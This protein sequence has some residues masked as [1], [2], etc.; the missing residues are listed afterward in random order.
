[1][2]VFSC[3][4][5]AHPSPQ[6]FFI[7]DGLFNTLVAVLLV[8]TFLIACASPLIRYGFRRRVIRLMGLNQVEPR[9]SSWWQANDKAA[10]KVI[11]P[12]GSDSAESMAGDRFSMAAAW[13]NRITLAT[14]L[15]WLA[16]ALMA[17]PV[18]E[19][20]DPA[21]GWLGQVEFAVAAG[22][23][24]LGPL[25]VNLPVHWRRKV[26]IMGLV[27]VAVAVG[28]L[29]IIDIPGP[30]S[31]PE[32][33]DD[34]WPAWLVSLWMAVFFGVYMTLFHRR[35]RGLVVP[36]SLVIAVFTMATVI[37][38]ALVE[39]HLGTCLWN[40]TAENPVL[41]DAQSQRFWGLLLTFAGISL[42]V[43]GLW[44]GL[45]AIGILARLVERGWLGDLSMVSVIGLGMIAFVMIFT[46][47]PGEGASY[48]L[49]VAWLPLV[50]L[51]APVG[52][53]IIVLGRRS[54]AGPGLDLLMLR[55][56]SRHSREQKFL[57]QVQSRWRYLGAVQQAGGP[58]LVDINVSPYEC[59][60][61]LSSRLHDLYLP[62]ALD[63]D[64]LRGRFNYLPDREGRYR[65]N[66]MF[67]FN[68]A[69]RNNVEQLI[70]LSKTIMLDL[71]G[72]TAE[73]EGT[74]YEIGLLARHGLLHRVVAIGDDTTDWAHVDRQLRSASASL[75]QLKRVDITSNQDQD[76]LIAEL[77]KVAV[78]QTS[79]PAQ[80]PENLSH[81][82]TI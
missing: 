61:F 39:E 76:A 50:W 78:R 41:D 56:F 47:I 73:R 15:A 27:T 32:D 49:W 64:Q 58:D 4:E 45:H 33:L 31:S 72:L 38:Y 71:R 26:L 22:A 55:V 74:S 42:A 20:S 34:E 54:E 2:S 48:S 37:P 40:L 69:W 36:L 16:F 82:H 79:A 29:E 3:L 51:A 24:A 30:V 21:G 43:L 9:P 59:A 35:L 46:N 6:D 14:I 65:I 44:L 77:L 52:V 1:V 5:Q 25:V 62:A 70:L 18:G 12:A 81:D 11:A 75:E 66:E 68:T 7:A 67:N 13:E 60:M 53:Y 19:W 17:L 8:A 10:Q 57:E 23:L 63:T 28:I 80:Q